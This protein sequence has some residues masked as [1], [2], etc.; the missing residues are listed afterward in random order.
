M[1]KRAAGGLET[2][3]AQTVQAAFPPLRLS[4]PKI[5]RL[6]GRGQTRV[7]VRLAPC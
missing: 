6:T 5:R 3:C 4:I 2:R 7:R 1:L